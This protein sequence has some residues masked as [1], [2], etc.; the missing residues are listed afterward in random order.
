MSS[1]ERES[2][3]EMEEVQLPRTVGEY[4]SNATEAQAHEIQQKLTNLLDPI[5]NDLSIALQHEIDQ[6]VK[7]AKKRHSAKKW[8]DRDIDPFFFIAERL[9]LRNP[10]QAGEDGRSEYCRDTIQDWRQKSSIN[11]ES[12]SVADWCV[13]H[14]QAIIKKKTH[15]A[16][17][18]QEKRRKLE[19]KNKQKRRASEFYVGGMTPRSPRVGSFSPRASSSTKK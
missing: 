11:F 1:K 4:G 14:S 15:A 10:A 19:A 12:N 16:R 7:A 2:K 17:R 18:K 13:A 8:T 5:L 6:K 3:A 9:L